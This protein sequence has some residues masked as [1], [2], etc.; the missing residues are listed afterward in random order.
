MKRAVLD[1]EKFLRLT[2]SGKLRGDVT[3]WV[4][5]SVRPVLIGGRR[6]I[7]FSYFDSKKSVTKNFSGDVLQNRL[8]EVLA[9]PFTRIHVQS[10]SGDIH[11]RITRKG[12]ALVTRGKPSSRREGPAL[13]HDHVKRYPLAVDAPDTFLQ[14]IGVMSERGKVLSSMQGKFRQINEFLRIIQQTIPRD[15]LTQQT[16][17]I[18]D[19]GCGSAYLTFAAYHYLNRV[20]GLPVHLVGIDMNE[21]LID[22]CNGLRDSLGWSGPEFYTSRIAD[23]T[24]VVPPDVVLSLHA[25]DTATDEAI[26]RGIL[27]GSRVILA[28]PCCQHE[29]HRQIRAPLLRPMLRHGVLRERFADLLTDTFRALVLR[30]MGYRTSVIEFVSPEHTTKNLMIRAEKGLKPGCADFVREYEDLKSFFNV[31]PIIEQLLGEEIQR[32]L[33]TPS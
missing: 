5:V 19:C 4:K 2:L 32:F 6:E 10:T 13:S 8:D 9:I 20:C 14:A 1:E 17:H 11:V 18:V 7:Q 30:I 24:P 12:K 28:A 3:P 25:C 15:D 27:W 31:S 29:L 21:E 26:A 23:F 16:I 22:R 33:R